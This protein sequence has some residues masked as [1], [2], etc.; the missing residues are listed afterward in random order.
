MSDALVGT[1][2]AQSSATAA[3][4]TVTGNG[5]PNAITAPAATAPQPEWFANFSDDNKGYVQ[6][7]GFKDPGAVVDSYRNLEKLLGAPKERL[8]TLPEKMDAESLKPIYDKL[9]RP[10]KPEEYKLNIRK[11][12]GDEKFT[13]WA[14]GTFHEHGLSSAQAEA[15]STKWDGFVASE[16]QVK[17]ESMKHTL[18]QQDTE[19]KKEW[20]NAYDQNSQIVDMAAER[21]GLDDEKI[22]RLG[23]ALGYAESM[24]FLHKLGSQIGEHNYVD[25]KAPSMNG[26]LSPAQAQSRLN[27]LKK[28][29]TWVTRYLKGDAEA[30]AESKRLNQMA[31]PEN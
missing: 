28:D 22:K 16:M 11:E 17:Q 5:V 25:G 21:L 23:A 6:N 24:K 8:L 19:L 1:P 2:G 26:I 4:I 10:A 27:E 7:K 18:T 13:Q 3:P 14:R 30:R 29:T 9:G 31:Y 20:G 15:L 12:F